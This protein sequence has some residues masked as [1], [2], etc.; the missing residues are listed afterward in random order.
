MEGENRKMGA[1]VVRG[2]GWGWLGAVVMG[3]GGGWG[4]VVGGG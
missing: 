2:G 3:G 4:G 1:V